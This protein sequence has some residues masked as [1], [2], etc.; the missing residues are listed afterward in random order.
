MNTYLS[1][2]AALELAEPIYVVGM[3]LAGRSALDVLREA[4]YDATGVDERSEG[5]HI[6]TA[7]FDDVQ[8][9]EAATLVMSPGI[10]RRR[11]CFADYFGT[12]VN[13]VELFACLVDKPVVAVTGSN[14][15]STVVTMLAEALN[16]GGTRAMLCGNIGYPVLSALINDAPADVYV[17]EL[18]SY[19]LECCPSLSPDVGCVLNV[20][21]DHLDRYDSIDSYAAA[22]ERLVIQSHLS[23][24][25]QD[26]AYCVAMADSATNVAWFGAQ[27]ENRV[28]DQGIYLDDALVLKHEALTVKGRHNL[29]N[30][31][32]VLMMLNA[33]GKLNDQAYQ[34]VST[35]AGLPHRM[36]VVAEVDGV[37]WFND[38]KA[39]NIGATQAAL[40]GVDAPLILIL[41]GVGKNQDF[42]LLSETLQTQTLRGVLLIGTDNHALSNALDQA[43]IE[44]ESVGTM[45][46]AVSRA[47]EIAQR[48]DWVL[49]SPACASFDQYR[50][51]AQR[52]E[53]FTQLVRGHGE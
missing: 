28:D 24:L 37:S 35:F 40:N 5:R 22:K 10:D 30:A 33:L 48:G 32:V 39:T 29:S 4:G 20:S 31:L 38:S 34:A 12:V 13:D 25:N 49:L 26:D 8:W 47:R 36:Q 45:D 17:L 21:P 7:A 42:H 14:G 46:R 27:T 15:K 23:I 11:A 19:Q 52:G 3:G 53:D 2:L 44:Y 51:F 9:S 41:G 50:G 1:R 43:C 16:A 6:R 18:S